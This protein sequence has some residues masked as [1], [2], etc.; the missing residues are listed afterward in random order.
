MPRALGLLLQLLHDQVVIFT[1]LDV[2]TVFAHGVADPLEAPFIHVLERL[3]PGECLAAG[4]HY[5]FHEC[6]TSA[7]GRRRAQHLD[8]VGRKRGVHLLPR[9][10]GV[11]DHRLR[12]GRSGTVLASAR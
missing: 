11:C 9:G 7:G 2:A 5:K 4:L 10:I 1:S 12:V 3:D 8:L 6:V